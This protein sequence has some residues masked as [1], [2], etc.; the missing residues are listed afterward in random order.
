MADPPGTIQISR[1]TI[2]QDLLMRYFV[3]I[4]GE[5]V[6]QLWPWKTRRFFVSPGQ[7][8]VRLSGKAAINWEPGR[9]SSDE[10]P[11]SVSPGQVR[12]LRTKSRGASGYLPTLREVAKTFPAWHPPAA[13][14]RRPWIALEVTEDI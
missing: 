5:V 11:V 10:I 3:L 4:D 13:M 14:Y 1:R 2:F 6:G 8:T 7:H 9:A 12:K